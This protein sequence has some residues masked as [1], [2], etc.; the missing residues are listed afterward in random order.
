LIFGNG[1]N[2]GDLDKLYFTAGLNDEANG[3]FGSLE[4]PIPPTF[5]LLGSGLAGLLGF[6]IIKRKGV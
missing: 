4:V 1:G 2:G 6:S 5:L 3:L